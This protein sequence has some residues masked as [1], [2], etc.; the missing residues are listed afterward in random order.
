MANKDEMSLPVDNNNTEKSHNFLPKYFRTDANKKFLSSTVDQFI[1]PGKLEKINSYAGRRH[2]ASRETADLYLN[3]VSSDRENY[4]FE[5]AL[6]SK[7]E[8]ENV[9][10]Y[11]DYNDYLG[12]IKKFNGDVSNHSKLNASEFYAWNSHID[13]DKFVNFREYYWLPNG[14]RSVAI[15]G[16]QRNAVST[17]KITNKLDSNSTVFV[18]T[19]NGIKYNPTLKLYKGQTYK[20]DINSPGYPVAI[21]TNRSY[22]DQDYSANIDIQ[23]TS[24]LYTTGIKKYIYKD[25]G[26]LEITTQHYIE[27]GVIEF[28]VSDTIPDT[29]FYISESDGD[30]S[31]ILNFFNISENSQI[32]VDNELIGKSTYT[33]GTGTKLSNGMKIHFEGT[34]TPLKYATGSWYVEGVGDSISL[35]PESDLV[36][37]N[38]FTTD[39]SSPFDTAVFDEDPL[40]VSITHPTIRDYISINRNSPDRNPWSR[41]NRWFH[42]SVIESSLLANNLPVVVDESLRAV[43]PIIEFESGLKLFNHGAKAKAQVDLVDTYTSDVFSTI[44]GSVGY[45]IDGVDLVNGMR[46]LFTADTDILVSGKIYKVR[47][48]THNLVKQISLVEEADAAPLEND[49]VLSKSGNSY[50]GKMFFYNG[51]NWNL[52]QEKTKINQ[53]PLFDLFDNL[54]NSLNDEILYDSSSFVGNKVFSYK[55]GNGIVDTELGFS[56]SY[57]SINNIGDIAFDFNLLTETVTYQTTSLTELA[58]NTDKAFLKKYNTDGTTFEFTS[59]WKKANVNSYQHVI[60][61]LQVSTILNNFDIDVYNNSSQLT[62]LKVMVLVNGVRKVENTDYTFDNTSNF[63]RVVFTKNLKVDDLV[64]FKCLSDTDKNTNGFYEMPINFE[65]NPLN[66]N[67]KSFTLGEVSDHLDSIVDSHPNFSG[68]HPGI[69]NLRDIG[70][71]AKYG[72]RFVKH[73]GPIN[74]ALY[75]LSANGDIINSLKYART[76]YA[77]FKRKLIFEIENT[78]F[79]GS[80]KDHADLA[81]SNLSKDFISSNS[82]KFMDM[83]GFGPTTKTSHTITSTNVLYFSLSSTFT[84]DTLSTKSVLVYKNDQQLLHD[85]DYT[86]KDGFINLLV[87]PSINDIIDIYEYDSTDSWFV[88]PTPT[89]LGL[90]PKFQ[91]MKYI[92]TTY[93]FDTPVS[94]IQGHDGSLIKAFDDYRDDIILEIEFRI[95]N[96]IKAKYDVN[97][98]DI[99]DFIKGKFRTKQSNTT[100][101]NN[102]LIND[103][104]SWNETAGNLVYSENNDFLSTDSFTYNYSYLNSYNNEVLQGSWRSIYKDYFDTDRPHSHP[105]EMIGFYI[106]PTWWD[107]VYGV[108]PYTKD[109]LILWQ[110]LSQGIIREPGKTIVKNKKYIRTDLL[111]YIPVDSSGNL[112]SPYDS[113]LAQEFNISTAN[114]S[115][116]FGDYSPVETAWRRSSEYPFA[117]LTAWV[118]SEPAKVMGLGFDTSRINRDL[119]TNLVYSSTQKQIELSAL[120]FPTF[121]N[122]QNIVYSSGLINYISAFLIGKNLNAYTLYKDTLT[123]LTNQLSIKLGGYADKSKLKLILDSRSPLNKSTV[124]VPDENYQIFF[125]TSSVI[126]LVSISGIIVEKSSKGYLISGYNNKRPFFDI[127]KTIRQAGDTLITVGGIS[128]DFVEWNQDEQYVSG[129]VVQYNDEFYRSAI[130]HESTENFDNKKFTKLPKLPLAGGT[131]ALVATHFEST[132]TRFNYGHLIET[133]QDLVDF[134]LG[135]E[136]YLQLQ[137]FIFDHFNNETQQVEDVNLLIKE[138]LFWTQQNWDNG[139]VLSLSPFANSLI[140][141]RKY[142]V[143]DNLKDSANNDY[144]I[145]SNDGSVV[146]NNTISVYRDEKN[147]FGIEPLDD[148]SSI[149]SVNLP[150][151]QKEH[152]ILIDNSTVFND[153]IYQTSTGYRQDRI[154]LVGHRTADWN[155]SYNIPGFIFD[156]PKVYNWNVWNDYTIGDVVQYKQYFYSANI[157]HSSTEKFNPELWTLLDKKPTRQL[158]PNWDY[159]ALQ[160]TEFYDLDNDNFDSEQQKMAQHLIGYQ[161]REYL[162]NIITDSSSQYKF[163]QGYIQEKGTKNSLTKL[164]DRLSTAKKDSLEFYEEWAIRVGNL[165][166]FD[167]INE[168]EF[169]LDESKIK[170]EPQIFELVDFE[171][172]R[173]DL[174]YEIPKNLLHITPEDYNNNP[175]TEKSN[176]EFSTRYSGFVNEK[177][178]SFIV[179]FR[180]NI[181]DLNINAISTGEFIWVTHELNSWNVYRVEHADELIINSFALNLPVGYQL[182]QQGNF[183]Q[184]FTCYFNGYVNLSV[185]DII[186]IRSDSIVTG[187]YKVNSLEVKD[188]LTEVGLLTTQAINEEEQFPAL[189]STNVLKLVTRKFPDVETANSL[190]IDLY[191]TPGDRI[192]LENNGSNVWEV[193]ENQNI[194]KLHN[195]IINPISLDDVAGAFGT[196]ISSNKL[197]N[198]V[199]IGSPTYNSVGQIGIFARNTE[200]ENLTLSQSRIADTTLHNTS[201][202]YG[203]ST[204]VTSNERFIAVGAP[205]ATNVKSKLVGV[206]TS[207]GNYS[208]GDIVLDRGILWEA[209]RT[210]SGDNSTITDQSQDWKVVSMLTA[211]KDGTSSSITNQGVVYLYEKNY[212]TGAYD[213]HSCIISPTPLANENFGYHVE[214]RKTI[215]EDTY[216]LFVGAPGSGRIYFIDYNGS[217]WNYSIDRKFKGNYSNS[218]Q[219]NNLDIVLYNGDLFQASITMAAGSNAPT[220]TAAWTDISNTTVEHTG[221][222]PRTG[223]NIADEAD[224]SSADSSVNIGKVF[225]V[226]ELGDV[227]AFKSS[228]GFNDKIS[229]YLNQLGRWTY[230][231]DINSANIHEQF[232]YCLAV[233]D[234][235]DKIAI[236]APGNDDDGMDQGCV[237][238]YKKTTTNNVSTYSLDQTLKSIYQESHESFGTSLDFSKNKLAVSA[239]NTDRRLVVSFDTYDEFIQNYIVDQLAD[240]TLV[241]SKYVLDSNGT[242]NGSNTTFDSNSTTFKNITKDTGRIFVFQDIG[243]NFIFAEDVDY[244]RKTTGLDLE[245]FVFSNNHIYVGLPNVDPADTSDSTIVNLTT[246]DTVGIVTDIRSSIN[247]DSWTSLAVQDGMINLDKIKR[248]LIYS[249]DTDDLLTSLDVVDCR[250]GRIPRVADI[251]IAYKTFYD[252]AIYSTNSQDELGNIVANIVVDESSAWNEEY[253]G[254][255][256]WNLSTSAWYDPY[257][258]DSHYRA[259]HRNKLIFGTS[260]DIY[261]WVG[262]TLTPSQWTALSNTNE[263]VSKGV[264]GVPL[265]GDQ[266]YSIKRVFDSVSKTFNEKYFYW[267]KNKQTIPSVNFRS[268]DAMSVANLISDP[269]SQGYRYVEILDTDKFVL[270]NCKS[271][272]EGTN[273][274]LRFEL[275]KNEKLETNL[276]REYQLL[277][278]GIIGRE[279]LNKEIEQKW[280]DSL[281]GYDLQEVKLPEMSLPVNNR[282]GI[283]NYPRQGMFINN[284]EALKQVIERANSVLCKYQI[285]DNYDI[286]KL[287]TYDN[288]PHADTGIY[289]SIVDT[290]A[291]LDNVIMAK[292]EKAELLPIISNG[293]IIRVDIVK[294]GRGYVNAPVIKII[295]STGT[296]GVLQSAI[297]NLGQVTSVTVK[298]SGKKYSTDTVLTVRDY[299]VLVKTDSTVENVWTIYKYNK[300]TRVWERTNIQSYDTRQYWSYK[301]WYATEYNKL[302]TI[303]KTVDQSYQLFSLDTNIGDIVKIKT[304]GTGGWLLLKK[305]NNIVTEDYTINYQTI[306]RENGTIELSATLYDTITTSKGFD[307]K[308][309]DTSFYDKEPVTELRTIMSVLKDNIFIAD[310]EVEYYNLFFASLRYAFAEQPGL[311]WAFKSSFVTAKHNLGTFKKTRSYQNDNLENYQDYVNEVKPFKTKVREYISSYENLSNTQTMTSDFDIPPSYYNGLIETSSAVYNKT[312]NSISNLESRYN[313]YPYKNWKDNV[314]FDVVSIKVVNGGSGYIDTPAVKIGDSDI[315]AYAYLKNGS[316]NSIDIVS[317]PKTLKFFEAPLITIGTSSNGTTATATAILGNS[318]VRSNHMI[319]K[320]DRVQGSYYVTTLSV[321]ESFTGTGSKKIFTL[322]WPMDIKTN[323]FSVTINSKLLISNNYTVEN[324]L[325]ITKGYDRYLG[326][327]TFNNPPLITDNIVITYKKDIGMLD[328]ADRINFFYTPTSNM[329]GKDLT[330]LLKGV[331]NSKS[332]YEGTNF[333]T[334]QGFEAQGFGIQPWDAFDSVYEDEIFILDGSTSVF[335]MSSALAD[336]VEYNVYLNG[337]RIDGPNFDGST[338]INN[339]RM[340]TIIGDGS[341]TVIILNE[342]VGTTDEDIVIIRKAVSDGSF[343]PSPES[344]DIALSGGNLGYTTATGVL[345]ESINVDGD[346]FVSPL[347]SQGPEEL[348]PGQLIDTL[349]IQVFHKPSEGV[350]KIDVVHYT[351]DTSTTTFALPGIPFSNSDIIVQL[352][353][354]ILPNELYSIN[355]VDNTLH[356]D[357]DSSY[358]IGGSNRVS[359]TT[360]GANGTDLI[361]RNSLT[362]VTGMSQIPTVAIWSTTV[363][364]ILTINGV[365]KTVGVDYNLVKSTTGKVIIELLNTANINNNDTVQYSLYNNTLKT[366]S[367]I[368]TDKTFIP[369][370]STTT[371]GFDGSINEVP[372]NNDP[373]SHKILLLV[374]DKVQTPGY[375]RTYTATSSRVYNIDSWQFTQ[376]GRLSST[377][378]Q[379]FVNNVELTTI[380][381]TYNPAEYTITLTDDLIAPVG[382]SI[383]VVIDKDADYKVRLDVIEFKTAPAEGKKVE[384]IHFSNHDVNKFERVALSVLTTSTTGEPSTLSSLT[385]GTPEYIKRQDVTRGIIKLTTP[386]SENRYVWV[387]KN[388]IMLDV[389]IDY[390]VNSKLNAVE[391]T[392]IPVELDTIDVLQFGN[393]TIDSFGYRMFKDMLNRTHYK[394]L[395]EENSY[396]LQSILNYNDNT[397]QLQSAT[398]IFQ[399]DVSKNI[400]GVIFVEGERIEYFTK[401]GNNLTQLRRGTL[402][403]GIKTTY[404]VDTKLYGQGPDENI[405]YNDTT[406][407]QTF[408]GNGSSATIDLNFTP[409]YGVNEVEIKVGGKRLRK[410]SIS[411]YNE[412]N[413]QDSTEGDSTNESEFTISNNTVTFN[414]IPLENERIEVYR[415]TGQIWNEIVSNSTTKSLGSSNNDISKFLLKATIQ[416]PK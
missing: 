216:R 168:L 321:S 415:K 320:F 52:A 79:H 341:T 54:Q 164:F 199:T 63:R 238:V 62:D 77:K 213:Y 43:R 140:F 292:F 369:D 228:D 266:A 302:T 181:L 132:I 376:P 308:L 7:D 180:D 370:G 318:V 72:R 28:T 23:N 194:F 344:F 70:N 413:D 405:L 338:I 69:N 116:V 342:I 159:K 179:T 89:K 312:T 67:I 138:F 234:H 129:V 144:V 410:T 6:V 254:K 41:T 393:A 397:I 267:V 117:L 333:G 225:D 36:T 212:Q 288:I 323:Q 275:L 90:Y 307:S 354:V 13:L 284:K 17:Y 306:G 82:F 272:I 263:G 86:F 110:D 2:S 18:V 9:N 217:T 48:H 124:F 402:G 88:P 106:K 71:L 4:Q 325:D 340:S 174:V 162:S 247:I 282:Y 314:G 128:E 358:E 273:S 166:S 409:T 171:T 227:L 218:A 262:S 11:K 45:N 257:Q 58:Y 408:I 202:N 210:V 256:W 193:Y 332:V 293:K 169:K 68:V 387:F 385:N 290:V 59:G 253:E 184:G 229:I 274:I 96:N 99:H 170:L 250:Q 243:S 356:I 131:T 173:N 233:N 362:Y 361:D 371:Y 287:S 187:F 208:A 222:V 414:T 5:P 298:N 115:W 346:D 403:T 400:P 235:G 160:F 299:T 331:S 278:E 249:L 91:P 390:I 157:T 146:T 245:N 156:D 223:M 231:Q 109:N 24:N 78:G 33:L 404:A 285:V 57:N 270:H 334:E 136:N 112:L 114:T 47:V 21:A 286:S 248:V 244:Q 281:V 265:Y 236:G 185:N 85:K 165:G 388:G 276:H 349:D 382:A 303:N 158:L 188:G 148:N 379:L 399:P 377:D 178:V 133:S 230:I 289:D 8:Y 189:S 25:D 368:I 280:L 65:K 83:I 416:L 176:N 19:P 384:L 241:Y 319:M 172:S 271:F 192:W 394:R 34:V 246:A 211:N 277:A 92:D 251:E 118:L 260:V 87:S 283:L 205:L 103:F 219:Y 316:V 348:V 353:G 75:H 42:K 95:F 204:A 294:S 220:V 161:P 309:Y 40:D 326:Y 200:F 111:N 38:A 268:L 398:G 12:V 134:L 56:L 14:P 151:V 207:G 191:S 150:L 163:Y 258:G 226:N 366:Y 147:T 363:T 139:T 380:Q 406:D 1:T 242:K 297:N 345:P 15:S 383:N 264:S 381:Y 295:S 155:G 396:K 261:E 324:K 30:T 240:H 108:A 209:L 120:V 76:E 311:D 327:I 197:N 37:T 122:T 373:W 113:G 329:P 317:H 412:L 123:G 372:F 328:A 98:L 196:S 10:F 22:I 301:D 214:I 177:N 330:Q 357:G 119:S 411:M 50:K 190:A 81:L 105:W 364:A 126:D 32:D 31:G 343:T 310:L 3:D 93:N 360:I 73:S 49:V 359:I 60:Q 395:N 322:K 97:K 315:I 374:D 365:I 44:E 375:S 167:N 339:V 391:L 154:K 335:H 255:L 135:Y 121:D 304:I 355:W 46:V 407:K 237:Y 153:T 143:V 74:L 51:K 29:L 141:E 130:T 186:G 351:L 269:A 94:V 195:E 100:K 305:T 142:H 20:F 367:Q 127:Y 66:E 392:N 221:Y 386:V 279:K 84:L 53:A 39:K 350:G 107:T 27:H 291:D 232:G 137:G 352:D 125:N 104:V 80:T 55:I 64:I 336:G 378:I 296:Y 198:I 401:T 149:Y 61:N 102:I 145:L 201:S 203:F 239:K 175:F 16:Q 215:A 152:I 300:T 101:I 35:I 337:I 182:D 313:N 26:S 183:V 206:L 347:T 259:A 389:N 224:D 252:P